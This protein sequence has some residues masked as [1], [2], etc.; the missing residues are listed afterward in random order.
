MKAKIFI[1]LISLILTKNTFAN[2][3]PQYLLGLIDSELK[4]VQRLNKQIKARDPELLLRLAELYL[5]RARVMK[6]IENKKYLSLPASKRRRVK[7]STFFKGSTSHFVKAQKVSYFIL[8]KFSNFDQKSEVYYIL[9]FNAKEFKKEKKAKS[10]FQKAFDQAS[11]RISKEK[12]SLALAEFFYNEKK[13]KK[14]IKYYEFA[15]GNESGKW[16]TKDAHNLAW[17]YFRQSRNSKAIKLMKKVIRLSESGDYL[18]MEREARRDLARFYA[19][20]DKVDEA[21][22]YLKGSGSVS[23]VISLAKNLIDQG[24]KTK[25]MK[26]LEGVISQGIDNPKDYKRAAESLMNIYA[27]YSKFE[28]MENVAR[29]LVETN[30]YDRELMVYNLKK[31]RSVI[32]KRIVSKRY[33]TQ[34]KYIKSLSKTNFGLG[35]I[36]VIVN[37]KESRSVHFYNA[38][39]FYASGDFEASLLE[40]KK[41]YDYK[42]YKKYLE[43]MM[44][45][46]SNISVES[47]IYKAESINVFEKYV[48]VEKKPAKK[49]PV[50]NR[51]FQAYLDSD[52]EKA[53]KLLTSYNKYYRGDT[54]TIEAMLARVL[55]H[56][57]V[58]NDPRKFLGYVKRINSGEFRVSKG[59]ASKIKLSALNIQ[60]KDVEK[61][62][63]RGSQIKALRGYYSIYKDSISSKDAKKNAAY[64]LAVLYQ[65]IGY[66]DKY[67]YWAKVALNLMSPEN[68]DQFFSSFKLFYEELF[69]RF[70]QS[71]SFDLLMKIN[72]KLCLLAKPSRKEAVRDFLLLKYASGE[73]RKADGVKMCLKDGENQKLFN[74]LYFS[75]LLNIKYFGTAFKFLN[76]KNIADVSESDLLRLVMHYRLD[77]N[78]LKT[79]SNYLGRSGKN[80]S[81]KSTL[82]TSLSLF[83]IRSIKKRIFQKKLIFPEKKFNSRLK[84]KFD[85]LNLLTS[86]VM[87]AVKL[88]SSTYVAELY[89]ILV[90]SYQ[91]LANEIQQF[92]PKGKG[93]DYV[94][95]FKGA[96]AKVYSPLYM[97]IKKLRAEG[98]KL[99]SSKKLFS[100]RGATLLSESGSGLDVEFS[101]GELVQPSEKEY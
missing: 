100:E 57:T 98:R 93:A 68:V 77:K 54:K 74:E 26:V 69:D 55:D 19:E 34:K 52:I 2:G 43:G 64:N 70:R 6:E 48:K 73:L 67:Y 78:K 84:Y 13:F 91:K 9:G 71:N 90:D 46:L 80:S 40:Y 95:S 101:L 14:A 65:K 5:E 23:G 1:F 44:A 39:A 75:R 63:T 20:S 18:N 92:S 25:A 85:Q 15:L 53:E 27:D 61:N 21:V 45:C 41:A 47:S 31:A 33:S 82:D 62:N 96:M 35:S 83:S 89:L 42:K 36:L 66:A 10:F 88:G 97:E 56:P 29:K 12:S 22:S 24:K 7:K 99:V 38:E 37:P 3:R 87:A 50:Y 8:K 4:E 79:I 32:Q 30:N 86:K 49:R 76:R 72:N 58:K 16:W 11:N 51:L 59:V 94:K 17:C 81:V 28:K 60:F